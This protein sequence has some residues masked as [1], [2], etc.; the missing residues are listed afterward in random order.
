MERKGC[1]DVLDSKV[2]ITEGKRSAQ[3]LVTTMPAKRVRRDGS[4]VA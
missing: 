2:Q 3:E 4:L 1:W